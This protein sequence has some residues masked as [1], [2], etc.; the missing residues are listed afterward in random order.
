MERCLNEAPPCCDEGSTG[1]T[2]VD[3]FDEEPEPSGDCTITLDELKNNDLISSLLAP[4]VDLFDADGN[5]NPRQ[6]MV[7]DSLS[8]GVGFSA[9][10]AVFTITP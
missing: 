10:G 3:L 2:L 1:E 4:D 9:V 5:F 7:K 8:L 6:D